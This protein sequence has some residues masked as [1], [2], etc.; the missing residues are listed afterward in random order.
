[1]PTQV[2][3]V[4]TDAS[5]TAAIEKAA[6]VILAGGLVAFP[7]ETVYGLGAN[8]LDEK[9]VRSIFRVKGRPAD[10]P[11]ILHVSS[12]EMLDTITRDRPPVAGRLIDCFWPGPLTLVLYRTGI[13]CDM[14]TGGLDTVAVRMPDNDTALSLIGGAGVPVAAP[15]ANRSGRPS[16]T[17]A[18]HVLEDLDGSID[19][20]LDGGRSA[21]GVE[22]TVL[23]LT[24]DVPLLLR[25]GGVS[26]EELTAAVG[27][28]RTVADT[29]DSAQAR[30]PGMKYRHYAP[31]AR[32][33]L[34]AGE[35]EAL[36]DAIKRLACD[37]EKEGRRVAIMATAG[38]L[39]KYQGCSDTVIN[40]GDAGDLPAVA[41]RLFHNLRLLDSCG[42][43]DII[44]EPV[45]EYGLG[46]AVMNRLR[47]AAGG[48]IIP[49]A[50]V[51][52]GGEAAGPLP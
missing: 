1:M 17:S 8:G 28:I 20:I 48:R 7:T 9:A 34:A 40:M 22:S 24:V 42:V 27:E 11:L 33:W 47:K 36:V 3:N 45:P 52:E 21:F 30:S 25:P 14:V 2:I 12:R 50:G 26:L 49:A 6:A 31:G 19:L 10:N 4:Q 15:S 16:P 51:L 18:R 37:L 29:M 46:F 44:A 38:N 39:L 41:S 13:V 32:V 23:D 5:N 35:G 43:D